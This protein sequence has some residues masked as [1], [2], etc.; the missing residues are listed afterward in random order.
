MGLQLHIDREREREREGMAKIWRRIRREEEERREGDVHAGG[1]EGE[2]GSTDRGREGE[3]REQEERRGV[4]RVVVT[5]T[6]RL[7]KVECSG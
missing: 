3:E 1:L 5:C 4:D 7:E 2:E 6:G